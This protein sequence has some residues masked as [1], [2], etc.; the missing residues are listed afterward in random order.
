VYGG[1]HGALPVAALL[2][3]ACA[4]L[5]VTL[6]TFLAYSTPYFPLDLTFERSVQSVRTPFLDAFTGAATWLGFF[7]QVDIM[8][9]LVIGGF[10]VSRR[11]IEA[12]MT[13]FAAGGAALL[14]WVIAP[15]VNRARPAP[16]LVNVSNLIGVGGFPSGHVLTMTAFYGFL[17]YL[18]FRLIRSGWWRALITGVALIVILGMGYGRIYVG[19]HWP[20]DVLA[21]YLF[22]TLWLAVTV[23]IYG[24][25][26]RHAYSK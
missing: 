17:I 16:E 11:A 24:A 14:F 1:S 18:T 5:S 13:L 6:L 22:G 26:Q 7:P 15:L 8:V 25:W 4:T 21:G 19:E 23:G 9:L 12:I 10:F 20:S 2:Y 3:V